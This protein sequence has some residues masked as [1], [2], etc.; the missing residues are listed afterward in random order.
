MKK[1]ESG[2]DFKFQ[3]DSINTQQALSESDHKYDFKFQSD[4]INTAF[5][6]LLLI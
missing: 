5:A 2:E 3:S 6:F 1:I 4:S